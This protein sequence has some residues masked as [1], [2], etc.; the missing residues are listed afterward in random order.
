MTEIMLVDADKVRSLNKDVRRML[1]HW[2][3]YFRGLVCRQVLKELE[4][5]EEEKNDSE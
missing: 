5:W 2:S 4:L 1:T 3:T